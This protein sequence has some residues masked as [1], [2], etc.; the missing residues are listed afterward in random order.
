[1][2]IAVHFGF[3]Y[4]LPLESFSLGFLPSLF[5]FSLQITIT[6]LSLIANIPSRNR[7]VSGHWC[8]NYVE[9]MT[10]NHVQWTMCASLG[11][12]DYASARTGGCSSAP[13]LC[14]HH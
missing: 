12:S 6:S 4:G 14:S 7:F 8:L 13:T 3:L 10:V 2:D 11:S 1:M 9:L 5:L